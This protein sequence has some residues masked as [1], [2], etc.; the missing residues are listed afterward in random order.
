MSFAMSYYH[1]FW[2]AQKHPFPENLINAAPDDWFLAHTNRHP[3]DPDLF[4]PQALA[5]Y[6]T[7][8]HQPA[9]ISGMCEDYRAAA[10][11]DLEHDRAS[12]AA[13]KKVQCLRS[14]PRSRPVP[15]FSHQ[16]FPVSSCWTCRI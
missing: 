5:E 8:I 2:F 3:R 12:R 4:Q 6:K 10:G 14:D 1:W 13:G 7:Y 15:D 16:T 9:M 11:I